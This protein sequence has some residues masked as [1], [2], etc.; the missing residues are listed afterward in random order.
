[1]ARDMEGTRTTKIQS[2]GLL[3]GGLF[4]ETHHRIFF[5]SLLLSPIEALVPLLTT[6]ASLAKSMRQVFGLKVPPTE[7]FLDG[8]WE[9]LCYN[10]TCARVAN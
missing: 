10:E 4:P 9:L 8:I 3:N 5:Q 1:M 2:V 6:R 7:A